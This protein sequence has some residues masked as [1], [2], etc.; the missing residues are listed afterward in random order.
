MLVAPT[1]AQLA[2]ATLAHASHAGIAGPSV[3]GTPPA[4]EALQPNDNRR[5]AGSLTAGV[6]T[7]K[8]VAR[9]GTYFPEGTDQPGIPVFAFAEEGRPLQAPG[10][11]IRVNAGT[12]IR[13]SV[14]NELGR[15]MTL[16]GLQDHG[17]SMLDTAMIAAGATRELRF[18]AV[19]PGTYLY[20]ARTSV[21]RPGQIGRDQDAELVGAFIVDAPGVKAPADERIFVIGSFED[22]LELPGKPRGIHELITVNGLSWPSTERFRFTVGD[23]VRWRVING[24]SIVHPMHLHGFYYDVLSKGDMT[25]DTLYTPGQQRKAVTEF[26]PGGAT[27]MMRWVPTRPGNWLF[28]CHLIFHIDASQRLGD[29]KHPI[30]HANHAE[31]AMAG[32]VLGITVAP[33]KG[34]ALA[35]DPIARRKLRVLVNERPRM[36]GERPG[37]SFV[38]Q[39]GAE[40]AKD[41]IRIP[42]STIVLHKNEPTEIT[43]VNRTSQMTSTHWHGIELESYYD[44]VADWSGAGTH[45]APVVAPGDSFVVRMTPDRAGTFI[46]H[47]HSNETVQLSGGLYGPLIVLPEGGVVDTTDRLFL[48]GDGGSFRQPVVN[49]TATPS[50]VEMRSGVTH[51]FRFVSISSANVTRIR[52]MSDSVLTWRP[53]AKD[54]ADL[55]SQRSVDG[56]AIVS[57][58]PG[59]TVDVE[60][61][62]SKPEVLTLEVATNPGPRQDLKRI[63]VIVR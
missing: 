44:G 28:H 35:G 53:F 30:G 1:L 23:T 56:A 59:E 40:P 49:G 2:V 50:P 20:F 18:R 38:L 48:F 5:P 9:A 21:T 13:A 10:P 61:R 52:L 12:E 14:R 60:V 58:G 43:V 15:P 51:R 39:D 22:T 62:H 55:P 29:A 45:T 7:I 27:M 54:G 26:M 24:G 63:P 17:S 8:L 42:S 31:D 6:L 46:Y 34:T 3:R 11:L 16:R 19:T 37:F 4:A 25:R 33:A 41:S 32:L 57:L 47:T 36:F